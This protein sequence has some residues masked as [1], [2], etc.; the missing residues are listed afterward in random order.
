MVKYL[1][2]ALAVLSLA[3]CK[4]QPAKIEYRPEVTPVYVVP[5]AP[6]VAKPDLAVNHLT[7]AQKEDIGQWTQALTISFAQVK[8]Y[9]CQLKTI[10]DKYQELAAQSP[11]PLQPTTTKPATQSISYLP[12]TNVYA[13][14]AQP[15]T[16]TLIVDFN[17]SCGIQ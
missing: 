6:A 8:L 14:A 9:A 7:A 13:D 10:V 2:I 5:K 15:D 16:Q 3:S 17:K 1:F 4:E 12:Q 11:T